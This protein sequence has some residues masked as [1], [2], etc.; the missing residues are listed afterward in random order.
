MKKNKYIIA[1]L[2][3]FLINIQNTYAACTQEEIDAFKKVEDEYTVKYEFD[4]SSKRYTMYFNTPE[5]EKYRFKIYSSKT[6]ECT[7][8]SDITKKCIKFPSGTYDIEIVGVTNT[9]NDVLKLIALTLPKYNK[10]SEDELC[11]GIEEFVLCNPTYEKEI[12]YETFVSRVTTYKK[13]KEKES[14]NTVDTEEPEKDKNTDK[15]I[16]Y[17]KDNLVQII[18]IATFV[19][20]VIITTIITAKS[21][22]KSRRLE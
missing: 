7:E 10:L 3:L 9:C 21:I 5:P 14:Q 15:I 8:I 4:T 22:R 6:L 12:D 17:I 18:I 1:A 11:K 19:I 16:N 20:L 2:M 13:T